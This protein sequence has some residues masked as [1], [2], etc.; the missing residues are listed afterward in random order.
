M[1]NRISMFLLGATL[2]LG[3]TTASY[4]LSNAIR[5]IKNDNGIKVKGY[6]EIPIKSDIA[7]WK[8]TINARDPDIK[9]A[10]N[11]IEN[12]IKIIA[13][14]IKSLNIPESEYRIGSASILEEKAIDESMR[15]QSF[16]LS[17]AVFC[18]S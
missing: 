8:L 13:Q 18:V 9:I 7:Q 12:D 11:I 10:Y 15:T 2:A 3:F 16:A 14:K 6:A 1:N 5:T 17:L 4:F